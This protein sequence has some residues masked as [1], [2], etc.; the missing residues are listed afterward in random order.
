MTG[1][2]LDEGVIRYEKKK[3]TAETAKEVRVLIERAKKLMPSAPCK[4]LEHIQKHNQSFTESRGK[5]TP[6]QQLAEPP[7]ISFLSSKVSGATPTPNPEKHLDY[8]PAKK[9][10]KENTTRT[11]SKQELVARR[12]EEGRESSKSRVEEIVRR[13]EGGLSA[14][15]RARRERQKERRRRQISKDIELD[16][17]K[18]QKQSVDRVQ[19][20]RRT[21]LLQ[22]LQLQ[23]AKVTSIQQQRHELGILRQQMRKNAAFQKFIVRTELEKAVIKSKVVPPK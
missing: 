23:E 17:H 5:K 14:A 19:E 6:I 20:N 15:E 22:R 13:L 7:S 11:L 18:E 2:L 8:P 21:Q 1:R 12:R 4:V 9:G 16:Q 3:R 10:G